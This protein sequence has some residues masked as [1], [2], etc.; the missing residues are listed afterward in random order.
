MYKYIKMLTS[1]F[2]TALL[3]LLFHKRH[4]CRPTVCI[5]LFCYSKSATVILYFS[6]FGTKRSERFVFQNP[7][8]LKGVIQNVKPFPFSS[9]VTAKP[10]TVWHT[11][12]CPLSWLCPPGVH[13]AVLRVTGTGEG[14]RLDS[15]RKRK[16]FRGNHF[17]ISA[18]LSKLFPLFLHQG[19]I[20]MYQFF[21]FCPHF[22]MLTQFDV[23]VTLLHHLLGLITTERTTAPPS[24]L[25][26][27]LILS[28]CFTG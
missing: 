18:F 8:M 10:L 11:K 12:V 21:L 9:Q 2:Q 22:L 26:F 16:L 23:L 4:C 20:L 19:I 25:S 13:S 6:G 28:A 14:F 3:L 24:G 17:C 1:C 5:T 27:S 7:G 15:G